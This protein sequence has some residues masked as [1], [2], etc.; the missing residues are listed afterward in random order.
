MTSR[1]ALRSSI[2]Q[3]SPLPSAVCY[4]IANEIQDTEITYNLL[5]DS[6]HSG[7][8]YTA[9]IF[10][11]G[12]ETEVDTGLL[13]DGP[14]KPSRLAVRLPV[15]RKFLTAL[16][17]DFFAVRI[18]RM[19]AGSHLWEHRDYV[20]LDE[21]KD[22][23]R[24]H[25]P[26][27]TNP[28][29]TIDFPGCKV[30]MAVGWIWKLDPTISHAA[31]NTGTGPRTHLI[32]DCYINA[33]LLDMLAGEALETKYV[34]T[35]ASLGFEARQEALRMA[36]TLFDRDGYVTAE[37]HLLQLFHNFNLHQETTY[38]ILADFYD[39]IDFM[40]RKR[41]WIQEQIFR[42]YDRKK[43]GLG[44]TRLQ[45]CV[46]QLF[47]LSLPV[48]KLPQ[49]QILWQVLSTM[50]QC[51]GFARA[52]IRGS[53]ARGSADIYS[54]I[55][56]L[57]EVLPHEFVSFIEQIDIK[58]KRQHNAVASGLVDVIV[59]D[60]GGIGY[61]YLLESE[62]RIC[63]LDLYITCQGRPWA[64]DGFR[65]EI[66]R[67]V[68]EEED[69][70]KHYSLL[71]QLHESTV[72]QEIRRLQLMETSVS[73]MLL[74]LNVL[75]VMIKKCLERGDAFVASSEHH[76]WRLC[77]VKLV[78][79]RFD[80]QYRDYGFYHLNRLGTEADDGGALLDNLH[81][82][83]VSPLTVL[84]L[85]YAHRYAMSFAQK[86]FPEECDRQRALLIAVTRHIMD[87]VPSNTKP[88]PLIDAGR[89]A[90]S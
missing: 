79:H 14:P 72:S 80:V 22:R 52:F 88:S 20:E 19:D 76:L 1:E 6:Y 17:L 48:K 71:Y 43:L 84:T 63:Q 16:N 27:I 87:D 89:L 60:F 61:I 69:S 35:K 34:Y 33:Q 13:R 66:C 29:A 49:W 25:I 90:T 37:Q 40:S 73:Q 15:T 26:L 51:P 3:L 24:L 55:D 85:Q 28:A 39:R 7:G 86:H 57:C 65:R 64:A 18:A 41:F 78:R 75:V 31:S 38:D 32:L 74:E 44:S 46:T 4:D 42:L 5:Y 70:L 53:L 30:H 45:R 10:T 83:F 59:K 36:Q 2:S 54:D 58:M 82:M 23:L 47:D 81:T 9:T 11:P 8:W 62:T 50:Q 12:P 67:K 77:F 21:A 68:C 56:L